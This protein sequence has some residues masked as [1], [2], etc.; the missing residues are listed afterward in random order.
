MVKWDLKQM[1]RDL[2][3]STLQLALA[4][5]NNNKAQAAKLLGLGRTAFLGKMKKHGMPLGPKILKKERP[6]NGKEARNK[7]SKKGKQGFKNASG[8]SSVSYPAANDTG[9]SRF[10]LLYPK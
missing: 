6:E 10:D 4:E 2:E 5:S 8:D 9:R 1:L 3:L 7:L